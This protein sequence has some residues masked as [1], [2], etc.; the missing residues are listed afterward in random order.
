MS[1]KCSKPSCQEK[2]AVELRIKGKP[3]FLCRHH[4]LLECKKWE[5]CTYDRYF[6]LT[7]GYNLRCYFGWS[8]TNSNFAFK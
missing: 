5:R 2:P 1:E 8:I 7:T 6:R 3:V 4:W